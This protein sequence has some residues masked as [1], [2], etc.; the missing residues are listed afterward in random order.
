M[1]GILHG[2]TELTG[3]LDLLWSGRPEE[4]VAMA[5]AFADVGGELADDDGHPLPVDASSF[6]HAKVVFRTS[7][8]SG[9]CCTPALAWGALD[10]ATFAARAETAIVAGA[11]IHYLSL[12]DL[13]AMRR[14]VGRPKDLR[15]AAELDALARAHHGLVRRPDTVTSMD[16]AVREALATDLTV[17]IT[18]TGRHSGEPRRLEIWMLC[19]DGR[20][21]ITGTPGPRSWL[22]NLQQDPTLVVH[23]KQGVPADLPARATVVHDEAT[24]R[25]VLGHEAAAWYRSQASLDDLVARAPM[26]ELQFDDA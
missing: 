21:F 25:E 10:V 23:L 3:D 5:R 15:R 16:D 12:D 17:D 26:V 8:A 9:D 13:V 7:K 2:S 6:A 20:Y 18:T 22:A 4:A 19:I 24:R 14:A 1:A 11:T